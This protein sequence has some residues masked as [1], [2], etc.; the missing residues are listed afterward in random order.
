MK[1]ARLSS[2]AAEPAL[3]RSSARRILMSN[4]VGEHL[5]QDA[6]GRAER[7]LARF[8]LLRLTPGFQCH[9]GPRGAGS[10]PE[11]RLNPT[12]IVTGRTNG[13]CGLE[14]HQRA[15]R[16][17]GAATIRTVLSLDKLTSNAVLRC[18]SE[19]NRF[20]IVSRQL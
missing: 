19:C 8:G 12:S 1:T 20:R 3:R 5:L 2:P 14:V 11:Q 6:L 15:A 4:A 9:D 7:P 10:Q 18:Y 16:S 13:R 17:F